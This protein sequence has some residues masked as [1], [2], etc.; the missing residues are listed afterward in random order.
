MFIITLLCNFL[1][2]PHTKWAHK[3]TILLEIH[4]IFSNSRTYSYNN[5]SSSNKITKLCNHIWLQDQWV[6]GTLTTPHQST[7]STILLINQNRQRLQQID[8]LQLMDLPTRISNI[9]QVWIH[10]WWRMR[11]APQIME[12]LQWT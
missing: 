12:G 1:L 2:T 4:L 7:V 3:N 5:N 10:Q 9:K 8:I 11:E 6:M